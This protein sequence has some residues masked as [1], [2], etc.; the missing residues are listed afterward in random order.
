[1]REKRERERRRGRREREGERL[2]MNCIFVVLLLCFGHIVVA[3]YMLVKHIE[4]N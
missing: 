4:L 3:T 2:Y 1:M